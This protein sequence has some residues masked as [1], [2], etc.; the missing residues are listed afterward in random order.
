MLLSV[1]V[2]LKWRSLW[3]VV[4]VLA[5][6]FFQI[7]VRLITIIICSHADLLIDGKAT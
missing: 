2:A 4:L 1:T 6:D 5:F 7:A 3:V